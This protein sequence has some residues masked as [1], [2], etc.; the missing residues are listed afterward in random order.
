MYGNI[1]TEKDGRFVMKLPWQGEKGFR[2]CAQGV[3]DWAGG[4]TGLLKP[5]PGE[6]LENVTIQLTRP[7]TIKGR[8]TDAN[9][10]GIARKQLR[11]FAL[12]DGSPYGTQFG[13]VSDDNGNF[14]FTRLSPDDYYVQVEPFSVRYEN[15]GQPVM[16]PAM[17]KVTANPDKP[18]ENVTLVLDEAVREN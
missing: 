2:L 17:A 16:T 11:V 7:C 13:A 4:Y 18:V 14:S 6:K 3:G 1:Q 10:N 15:N 12:V 8:V 5:R 9:G